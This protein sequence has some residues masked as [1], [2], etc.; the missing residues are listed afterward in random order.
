M[1]DADTGGRAHFLEVPLP[2]TVGSSDIASTASMLAPHTPGPWSACARPACPHA[3]GLS[4]G[5]P[6][7]HPVAAEVV[8]GQERRWIAALREAWGGRGRRS[9]FEARAWHAYEVLQALDCFSLAICMLDLECESGDEQAVPIGA[10]LPHVE[11]PPGRR[12]VSGVTCAE[13]GDA[14][15]VRIWVSAPGEVTLE[16]YPLS[17]S[18]VELEIPVRSL[19]SQRYGSAG[20]TLTASDDGPVQTLAVRIAAG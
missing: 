15:D 10:A 3:L 5:E 7:G 6:V 13:G 14:V 2:D 1:F 4:D 17:R 9:T 18:G 12:L 11:Q 16:P 8:A 19:E 20:E